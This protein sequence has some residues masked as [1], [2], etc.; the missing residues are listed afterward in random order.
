MITVLNVI[1][2]V[3]MFTLVCC[4][5]YIFLYLTVRVISYI[6]DKKVTKNTEL[7]ILIISFIIT[8]TQ[9]TFYDIY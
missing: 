8:L 6:I 3:S 1:S 5:I 4:L 7:V 2:K 9:F